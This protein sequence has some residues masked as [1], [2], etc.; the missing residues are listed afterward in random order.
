MD[1]PAIARHTQLVKA[2][3]DPWIKT[4]KEW[5]S[6]NVPRAC[7]CPCP[8]APRAHWGAENSGH[9]GALG[10]KERSTLVG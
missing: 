6:P 1:V 5:R 3:V 9:R 7:P 8:C 2:A 4:I 10:K